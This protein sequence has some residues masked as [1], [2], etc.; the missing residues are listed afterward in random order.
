VGGGCG[1]GGG[2]GGGGGGLAGRR[3][4]F[5]GARP[6]AERGGRFWNWLGDLK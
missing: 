6:D 4:R 3:R 2:G 1:E 5:V